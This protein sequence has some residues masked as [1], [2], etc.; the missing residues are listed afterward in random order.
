M[1]EIYKGCSDAS[2][3]TTGNHG[4][5]KIRV[6]SCGNALT[7]TVGNKLRHHIYRPEHLHGKCI[8]QEDMDIADGAVTG[9]MLMK[10][11]KASKAKA[12]EQ[13]K[14]KPQEQT[15]DVEVND[16]VPV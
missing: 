13:A 16:A 14:A 8:Q 4:V 5:A 2:F 12:A 3:H 1:K 10:E 6:T 11:M 9:L 15:Q 7:V